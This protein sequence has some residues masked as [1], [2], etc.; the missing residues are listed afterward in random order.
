[1]NRIT[2]AV[3]IGGLSVLASCAG[4][5][6]PPADMAAPADLTSCAAEQY[7]PLL[8]QSEEALLRTLIL[9]QVRV[10]RPGQS[11]SDEIRPERITFEVDE[12]GRISDLRCG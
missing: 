4:L 12:A 10:I 9:R 3:A 6:P 7:L 1:M 11:A 2:G 8:G 5:N